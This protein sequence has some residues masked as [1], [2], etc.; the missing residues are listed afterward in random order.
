MKSLSKT[1]ANQETINFELKFNV[2]K[3]KSTHF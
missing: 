1:L 2:F 3:I